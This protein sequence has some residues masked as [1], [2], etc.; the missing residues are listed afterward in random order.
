MAREASCGQA[1]GFFVLTAGIAPVER[2]H[3]PA[4]KR[5]RGV[6]VL[7]LAAIVMAI[8]SQFGELTPNPTNPRTISAGAM[9]RIGN[10]VP[11]LLMKAIAEHIKQEILP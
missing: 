7:D 9:A 2:P 5:A 8:N 11:S 6:S 10:C 3:C 4:K 1:S